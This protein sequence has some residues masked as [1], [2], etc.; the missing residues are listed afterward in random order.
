MILHRQ[1]L[2]GDAGDAGHV[3]CIDGHA[4]ALVQIAADLLRHALRI[5]EALRIGVDVV[6]VVGHGLGGGGD[7]RIAVLLPGGAAAL[8]DP[9]AGD[10]LLEHVLVDGH[11]AVGGVEGPRVGV[12]DGA[13]HDGAHQRPGAAAVEV[14][15]LA[16]IRNDEGGVRSVVDGRGDHLGLIAQAH[17]LADVGIDLAQP[18]AAAHDGHLQ[19]F[20]D[21]EEAEDFIL[22]LP[23][24]LIDHLGIAGHGQLVAGVAAEEVLED[25]AEEQDAAHVGQHA[26]RLEALLDDLEHGVIF[27]GMVAADRIHALRA[28]AVE[29]LHGLGGGLAVAIGDGHLANVALP[30]QEHEVRAEGIDAHA[31]QTISVALNEVLQALQH[32]L[33]PTVDVAHV[34][35]LQAQILRMKAVQFIQLQL[36]IFKISR[37][38]AA[39]AC[40]DVDGDV[41]PGMLLVHIFAVQPGSPPLIVLSLSAYRTKNT[42]SI[43]PPDRCWPCAKRTQLLYTV[44]Q[45]ILID[46]AVD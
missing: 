9:H 39:A 22:P 19:G 2:E 8:H 37:E 38:Q 43:H 44:G 42:V 15:A 7:L 1:A 24:L 18:V 4:V 3:I 11:V 36:T 28:E 10:V 12:E 46:E 45:Y 32:M 35:I 40:A 25:V 26:V 17:E 23:G 6:A 20:V 29:Q 27:H 31:L 21:V 30:I 16:Q 41:V 34:L 14:A 13:I 5:E 33:V